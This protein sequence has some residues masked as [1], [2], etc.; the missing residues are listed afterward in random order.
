MQAQKKRKVCRRWIMR[1]AD[2]EARRWRRKTVAESVDGSMM[3]VG[4]LLF[5]SLKVHVYVDVHIGMVLVRSFVLPAK[6]EEL[7]AVWP[8]HFDVTCPPHGS[9]EQVPCPASGSKS[10]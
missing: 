1:N 6:Q 2:L 4:Y 8:V 7:A 10:V 5:Q 3:V 9:E